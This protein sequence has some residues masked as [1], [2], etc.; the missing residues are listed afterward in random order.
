MRRKT[1]RTVVF[2]CV[3]MFALIPTFLTAQEFPT[4]PITVRST[5]GAGTP[6]DVAFRLLASRVEKS[7]GQPFVIINDTTG[8]GMIAMNTIAKE[9][10][11]GYNLLLGT[12]TTFIWVP[13]FRTVNIKYQDYTQIMQ[14]GSGLTGLVVR[15]DA[16]YKTLKELVAYAKKNPGK[17]SYGATAQSTPKQ[18]G[19]EVIQKQDGFDWSFVPYDADN[20]SL[21]A[22]MGG[23][24]DACSAATAFIPYVQQ[25]RLRLLATYME[26]R[27]K[28]FPDVPTLKEL[29]YNFLDPAV[30]NI[31]GPKGL[32]PATIK[33]LDE[34][35]HKAMGDPEFVQIMA[36]G[37][38]PILYR[39]SADLTKFVEQSYVSIGKM[40]V[41]YKLPKE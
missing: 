2:L 33:K 34:A 1:W 38:M 26:N 4:K 19:P 6:F 21:A 20:L 16:P 24:I 14:F 10:P 29:G 41:D 37:E 11:D 25:G 35:F 36:K 3:A 31:A 9:K 39:N 7:L 12:T 15:A 18:V 28:T 5:F 40:I 8:G 17:L 22:L 13:Q 27:S 30:Y 23:H 32:P